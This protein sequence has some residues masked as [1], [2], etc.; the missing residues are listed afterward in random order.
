MSFAVFLKECVGLRGRFDR[1]AKLTFR[2][3]SYSSDVYEFSS[4]PLWEEEFEWELKSKLT[5]SDSI[6]IQVLNYS[7]LFRHRLIGRFHMYLKNLIDEPY[8]LITD[9]LVDRNSTVLKSRITVELLHSQEYPREISFGNFHPVEVEE[10]IYDD[11]E[12]ES[13]RTSRGGSRFTIKSVKSKLGSIFS[14]VSQA[15]SKAY[16]L[17]EEGG[18]EEDET[19]GDPAKPKKTERPKIKEKFNL[20]PKVRVDLKPARESIDVNVQLRIIEAVQL[21][22]TQLD[23]VCDITCFGETK[24]T[25][26]KEQTNTPFWDEFFVFDTTGQRDII[27]DDIV[28]FKIY[29]AR[30]MLSK[31]TLMGFYKIDIGTIYHNPDHRFLRK[32]ACLINPDEILG[33]SGAGIKGYL[34]VDITVLVTGD[35][36]KEPPNLKE[37]TD[38]DG[39]PLLPEGV[40]AERLRT[41]ICVRIYKAEGLPKMNS[42]ILAKIRKS[43]SGEP[44]IRDLADPFVKVQWAGMEASTSVKFKSYDPEWS[45]EIVFCDIFPTLCRRIK[46]LLMDKD[47]KGNETIATCWIDL[48]EISNDGCNVHKFSLNAGFMPTFGPAWINLYGS[49]R[50][51]TFIDQNNFLNHGLEEGIGYRGRLLLEIFTEEGESAHDEE[52]SNIEVKGTS[53]VSNVIGGK[54]DTFQLFC[55]IYEATLI[56]RKTAKKPIRFEMNIENYGNTIDGKLV[57]WKEDDD[58][59]EEEEDKF[60][61]PL[62][63]PSDAVTLDREYYNMPYNESKPCIHI[64]FMLEDQRRRLYQQNILH[65]F[66]EN[67]ED[68]MEDVTDKLAIDAEDTY[69]FLQDALKGFIAYSE[70][71]GAQLSGKI[72]GPKAGKTK[73]DKE[74]LALCISEA[75]ILKEEA[76]E[77]LSGLTDNSRINSNYNKVLGFRDRIKKLMKEPQEST[78]DV[79]IWLLV[80]DKRHSYVR[81]PAHKIMYSTVLHESGRDSGKIQTYFLSLPGKSGLGEKGWAIQCKLQCLLWLGVLKNKKDMLL[82]VPLGFTMPPKLDRSTAPPP[83]ELVYTEYHKYTLRSHLYQARGLI[84]S[85]DSGLSDAFARVLFLDKAADTKVIWETRSPSWNQTLI[86]YDLVIW[87]DNDIIKINPPLIVIEIFDFDEGGEIEFIGRAMSRPLVKLCDEPYEKPLFPPKLEWFDIFRGENPSGEILGAFE[88]FELPEDED[89]ECYIPPPPEE[90]EDEENGGTYYLV[91]DNIRPVMAPHRIECLFW[92]VRE[93]KKINFQSVDRPRV[94]IDCVGESVKSPLIES[95]KKNPNFLEPWACF[96]LELPEEDRYCPPLTITVKDKRMFGKEILVGTA[97]INSLLRYLVSSEDYM[98]ESGDDGEEEEEEGKVDEIVEQGEKEGDGEVNEGFHEEEMGSKV[99]SKAASRQ[100]SKAASRQGSKAGSVQGSRAGSTAGSRVGSKA[101]SKA[102]SAVG[103]KVVS[104]HGSIA[105]SHASAMGSKAASKPQSILSKRNGSFAPS[106]VSA[107]SVSFAAATTH[108]SRAGSKRGTPNKSQYNS[109]VRSIAGSQSSQIHHHIRSNPGTPV[110]RAR[111]PKKSPLRKTSQKS[112]DKS[113]EIIEM[114]EIK[115]S[116]GK[117]SLGEIIS[118][119]IKSLGSK[120]ATPINSKSGSQTKGSIAAS[121]A[122]KGGSYTSLRG[123]KKSL[124]EEDIEL[125]LGAEAA[126]YFPNEEDYMDDIA[127]E[128]DGIEGEGNFD[129]E[130]GEG[131]E[132]EE[133]APAEESQQEPEPPGLDEEGGGEEEE[134]DQVEL[135]II[136][137]GED[138][139]KAEL[140]ALEAEAEEEDDDEEEEKEDDDDDDEQV[141]WWSRFYETIKDE[142]R[143]AEERKIAMK[144]GKKEATVEEGEEEGEEAAPVKITKIINPKI[145][146]VK[147]YK[148]E[149]EEVPAFDGFND[150]LHSFIL[151]RGKSSG[152][153]DED[154]SRIYGKFKGNFKVWKY[155]LPP[156]FDNEIL[157]MGSFK[158]LPTQ[159]PVSVLCRVYIVKAIDLHPTDMDGKADPYVKI[160]IGKQITVDRANFVPKQLNPNF[161]RVFDFEIIIPHDNMLTVSVYDYDLVGQDE[162]IGETKID[163]ENRF[164]TMHRATCG[165]SLRY[166]LQGY[167]KWR[168]PVKPSAILQRLCKDYKLDGPHFQPGKCRIQKWIFCAPDTILDDA[169]NPKPSDEPCAL[170]ALHNF[171]M[172]EDKGFPLVPEHVETRSLMSP[173]QPGIEQGRVQLWVDLFS[174]EGP[175]P[176][177]EIDITPR[178]PTAFELRCIIWNTEDVILGDINVMTGNPCADIYV[179]GWVDG[180]RGNKQSTDIHN[181]SLT[182]EGNFNWRFIFPFKFHKAEEKVVITKMPSLFSWTATEEKVP[183]RLILQCWDSDALSSDD[184]VGDLALNLVEMPCPSKSGVQCTIETM[185]GEKK[186]NIFKKKLIKGWWPFILNTEESEP[187]LVGKVEAELQLLTELE[188]E[189]DPA[190]LGRKEPNPLDFPNRPDIGMTWMMNPL[191]ALQNFLWAQYKFCL[192]K[193]AVLA[194]ILAIMGLFLYKAPGY[195]VKKMFG[196]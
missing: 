32:Y 148:T 51:Y 155:P 15:E 196:T 178:K 62:T 147:I 29:T 141:D 7:R 123:S 84:G 31:G 35:P 9:Y 176:G 83:N 108:P 153:D 174:M 61:H 37:D 151:L 100:G 189:E 137:I 113:S 188:A 109:P 120:L 112:G 133:E 22:G 47:A 25:Q 42:A 118:T 115:P 68:A 195:V 11:W 111:T 128:G 125:E 121:K 78:P 49:T 45:E 150:I 74:R 55:C 50:D 16:A 73:L 180:I 65:K 72:T 88:L 192:A 185:S 165:M 87:G 132:D 110:R 170:K 89:T 92:G 136:M 33:A 44:R 152:N 59:E 43:F 52:I 194:A 40:K 103:S 54:E 75:K 130:E 149:L 114:S 164:F 58:E 171:N 60:V 131:A 36:I 77:L 169:G 21:A 187:E 79:I 57:S 98:D 119:P 182:G 48:S 107:K 95:A 12:I 4:N 186:L 101:G 157:T 173:S 82:H 90:V 126:D 30:T 13:V 139:L 140:A 166:H 6:E 104:K 17:L 46:I 34:K 8:L 67:L 142:E 76:E 71:V 91:P 99:G 116:P 97:I 2:G 93:M 106:H 145:I 127:E 80:G 143:A 129:G 162:L 156:L 94:E 28:M 134:E 70:K 168:D 64:R 86:F 122:S 167:N 66:I 161:G 159:D 184:F 179:K 23:P 191:K 19:D 163:I 102:W 20:H 27:F 5:V 1:I 177:A 144:K 85:D 138:E 117:R 53:P 39:N 18:V 190:G 10:R 14:G 69:E 3:K 26:V 172:V 124:H 193:F 105:P 160:K 24:S 154:E 146:R 158:R 175:S 135:K 96:D 181:S 56:D 183:A 41:R 38:V 63:P 81:I